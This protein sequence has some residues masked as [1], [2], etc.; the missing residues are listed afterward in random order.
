MDKRIVT[1]TAAAAA[2]FVL[3][4]SAETADRRAFEKTRA[5]VDGPAVAGP[6]APVEPAKVE[7][8][9]N[10]LLESAATG[11]TPSQ[12]AAVSERDIAA[13]S[14]ELDRLKT[15][16]PEKLVS[17]IADSVSGT[18][19]PFPA[20]YLLAIAFAET[21]GKVLAVSPAGAA[22]LAQATPAAYLM[23][24]LGGKVYVTND[25]LVGTRAYIMKKPLGDVIGILGPVIRRNTPANRKRA[26]EL[27][28]KAKKVRTTGIEE[29]EA[30]EPLAPP[31]FMKRVRDA[32]VYN[33]ATL[34]ETEKLLRSGASTAKLK[35]FNNRVKRE[36]R[37]LMKVQQITW[38]RYA[39]SL[40][41][42]RDSILRAEF[43][44]DPKKVILDRPY[45]AGELLAEKLDAR[46]SP[47]QM[48]RFLSAHLDTKQQQARELG[49]PD[50]EIEQWTAALYNGGLVNV[51]RLREGLLDSLRETEN[52]M[53]KVPATK[54]RLENAMESKG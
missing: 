29:L 47:T 36:Y 45:E 44:G 11:V 51:S 52:Y 48:A 21:H 28:A 1:A 2:G 37:S 16:H 50:D 13:L 19:A 38:V 20:S 17:V 39:K 42:R 33:L 24:K 43:G 15:R 34:E 4:V 7:V 53:R 10:P 3:V 22:G 30:L 8:V 27:V 40:E 35:A 5:I 14:A 18:A 6:V 9:E 54:E 25:Y 23:E 49:V 26:L 41:K 32:D 31:V 46:F 12:L